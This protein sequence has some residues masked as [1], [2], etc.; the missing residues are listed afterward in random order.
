MH[1]TNSG[2]KA[3]PHDIA[4]VIADFMNKNHLV[5]AVNE[6]KFSDIVPRPRNSLLKNEAEIILPDWKQTLNNILNQKKIP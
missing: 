3:T 2:D 1:F 5:T 6:S 4:I